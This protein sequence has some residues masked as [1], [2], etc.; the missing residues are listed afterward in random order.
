MLNPTSAQQTQFAAAC[1][2]LAVIRDAVCRAT[3]TERETDELVAD[4]MYPY[5][6]RIRFDGRQCV[7]GGLTAPGQPVEF[8]ER[9][10]RQIADLLL[11]G[12]K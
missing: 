6:H 5:A 8:Q 7:N 11:A 1:E 12:T 10:Y 2:R 4:A 9:I 3:S